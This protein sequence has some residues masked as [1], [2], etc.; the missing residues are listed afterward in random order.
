MAATVSVKGQVVIPKA[1]RKALGITPG[2]RVEFALAR[3][4]ARLKVVQRKTSRPEDGYGMLRYEGPP[5]R[6]SEFDVAKAM[7]RDRR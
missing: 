6:L 1:I 4:E 2:S 5:H 7:R 3:G